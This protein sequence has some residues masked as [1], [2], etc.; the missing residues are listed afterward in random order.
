MSGDRIASL[1]GIL[2]GIYWAVMGFIYG[3]WKDFGPGSGFIPVVFGLLTA[4]LSLIL[5]IQTLRVEKGESLDR[6]E[7]RV[8]G[9]IM[10]TV[11]AA[12]ISLNI[13]GTIFTLII[14]II[15][16][17]RFLERYTWFSAAKVSAGTAIIAYLVF[18]LWLRV[19]L[20]TGVLGF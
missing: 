16:W 17:L 19:P 10:A 8:I 7:L 18:V 20:P 12:L 1:V 3:F 2:M 5:L 6:Q 14:L 13:L 9:K 11:A 4:V 15:A